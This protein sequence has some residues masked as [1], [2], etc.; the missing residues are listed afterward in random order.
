MKKQSSCLLLAYHTP[1]SPILLFFAEHA[2][3]LPFCLYPPFRFFAPHNFA[4][5][6]MHISQ[7]VRKQMSWTKRNAR[8]TRRTRR[9]LMKIWTGKGNTQ[10]A[11]EAQQNGGGEQII[12]F[13]MNY[14]RPI[15]GGAQNQNRKKKEQKTSIISLFFLSVLRTLFTK[16]EVDKSSSLVN[17]KY[18]FIILFCYPLF[19]LFCSLFS[20][21]FSF[22]CYFFYFWQFDRKI[23][24]IPIVFLDSF[25]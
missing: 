8:G 5:L 6:F 12:F 10:S 9:K 3:F 4:Q 15:G 1:H 14:S 16:R 23:V 11:K 20:L 18:I 2:L 13:I 7:I 21:F 22:S 25:N 17:L 19:F 24:M